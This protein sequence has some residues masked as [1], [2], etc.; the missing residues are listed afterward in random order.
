M[1]FIL[2]LGLGVALSII[3]LISITLMVAIRATEPKE[4]LKNKVNN[5]EKEVNDLKNKRMSNKDEG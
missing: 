4:D 5:L 3:T 2:L 1:E